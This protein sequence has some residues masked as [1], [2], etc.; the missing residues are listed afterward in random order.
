MSAKINIVN[1]K[2]GYNYHLEEKYIA[3]IALT[4]TEVKSVRN[5][6]A[7]LAEAYCVFKNHELYLVQMHISEW[8]YGSYLNHNPTRE[9]KLLLQKKELRKLKKG[10][11]AEGYTLI[12][13]RVF[14]SP[15]GLIKIEIA[16]AKGKKT[17]DKREDIKKKDLERELNRK[18]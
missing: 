11:E 13:V 5:N 12:P 15:I 4:G 3:G 17:V 1:K 9:R 14:T 16:L 6:N 8:K 18:F 2:A 10:I 7:S